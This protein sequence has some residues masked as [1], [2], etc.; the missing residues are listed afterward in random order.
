MNEL[1]MLDALANLADAVDAAGRYVPSR[2]LDQAR[3]IIKQLQKEYAPGQT[4]C[5]CP[6]ACL[7]HPAESK[8]AELQQSPAVPLSGPIP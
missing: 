6:F 7:V 1:K 8:T 2:S 4:G 5:T 3:Q